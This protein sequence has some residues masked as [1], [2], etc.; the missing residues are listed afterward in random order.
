MCNCW[1]WANWNVGFRSFYIWQNSRRILSMDE[2]QDLA[3]SNTLFW[4]AF[5]RHLSFSFIK[6]HNLMASFP[7][8]SPPFIF[9]FLFFVCIR[10]YLCFVLRIFIFLHTY[11]SILSNVFTKK[12]ILIE[13]YMWESL[14][15][16]V[17]VRARVCVCVWRSYGCIL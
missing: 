7:F 1:Q 6:M 8:I 13:M 9:F 4:P 3:D 5:F 15:V 2:I 12:Y 11:I 17:C 10:F 16:C 14:Y